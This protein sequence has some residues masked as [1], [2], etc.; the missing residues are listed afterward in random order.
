MSACILMCSRECGYGCVY[1]CLRLCPSIPR[2]YLLCTKYSFTICIQFLTSTKTVQIRTNHIRH[3]IC[4]C[5]SLACDRVTLTEVSSVLWSSIS[6][7]TRGGGAGRKKISDIDIWGWRWWW[8]RVFKNFLRQF[9]K[10]NPQEVRHSQLKSLL[11]GSKA[12]TIYYTR[13]WT[14]T[15]LPRGFPTQLFCSHSFACL[16]EAILHYYTKTRYIFPK[17]ETSR[18]Q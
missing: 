12:R 18:V 13:L 2:F 14:A 3:L 1:P 17:Y 15:C 7:T 16:D 5:K 10:R 11:S 9:S 8:G 4:P 6:F